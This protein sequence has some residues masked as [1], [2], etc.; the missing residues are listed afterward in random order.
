MDKTPRAPGASP[1]AGSRT[2]GGRRW[3]GLRA[4]A[5]AAVLA[6]A[7][8]W[9]VDVIDGDAL[10]TVWNGV[11]SAPGA[12]VLALL[13]YAAAFA[14][15]TAVWCRVQPALPPGQAWAALHVALAANHVLPLRLG[16]VLRVLSVLRRTSL[17]ARPVIAAVALLRLGDL[18]ALVVI[19]AVAAPVALLAVVG[20]AGA[21]AV[22]GASACAVG[23]AWW[24]CRRVVRLAG[25]G[26]ATTLRSPDLLVALGT[27]SAWLL[28]AGVLWVVADAAGLGLSVAEAAGV[29]AITV[30]AQILAV[31][32]GGVGTYEAAGTAG[33]VALG[34]G[35]GEA[36]A[37]VFITH[38]VKTAYSLALGPVA[39]LAP[40][41]GYWGGWRLPRVLPARPAPCESVAPEA[42]VVVFLPAH[43]EEQVI[44]SVIERIPSRVEG[45]AV[46]VLV[47][48]DGSSDATAERARR[49]GAQVLSLGRNHG[50]GAAV[51]RGLAEAA[52]RSPVAGVYLDADG[53]YP[54]E[55]IPAVVAPVLRG[56]A[57]YVIG[58]RFA[59]R[60]DS[61]RPHR[62]LGNLVLTRWLRWTAR[63][64]DLTDGQS[65]FRAFSPA[66]LADAEVVH[67]YN[68]AQVLTLDLL[69]KGYRY[70][71]VPISYAFRTT[72]TSF[73]SLGRYLRKVVPAVHRELNG[74][75]R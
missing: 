19:A 13:A 27:V 66:A 65:G 32:P 57:D 4:L 56:E 50:L 40:A 34:F 43:D 28:E 60:I 58:S 39:L 41:P 36:F 55:E 14:L 44:A 11:R 37:V 64:R 31:T 67:D 47:I 22:A 30:F 46:E 62:R 71:E 53:E 9:L 42:P 12:M 23:I 45:R 10:V 74:A 7:L 18:L 49:A 52:A 17:P 20:G 59:G 48:D 25:P 2:L 61:M 73:V 26:N 63:R 75:Q 54:P 70:A 24:W 72:G 35:A 69:A 5:G 6:A 15:R 8:W 38:A 51:R 21:A 29:T 1:S 3:A 16:E 68:Y 33:L